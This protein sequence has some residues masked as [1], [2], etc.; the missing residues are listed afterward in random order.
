VNVHTFRNIYL[1]SPYYSIR[2]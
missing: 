1:N 2:A